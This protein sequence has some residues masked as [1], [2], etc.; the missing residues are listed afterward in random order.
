MRAVGEVKNY[1]GF[2]FCRLA[3]D[4]DFVRGVSLAARCHRSTIWLIVRPPA[5]SK[6]PGRRCRYMHHCNWKMLVENQTDTCHPMVAHESSA[7]TAVKLWEELDMP[8]GTPLPPAMEIIAPFTSPYEFFENMGIRTW[9]N[10]HGHTGV[11]HSIH[12]NYSAD[13]RVTWRGWLSPMARKRPRQ[14]WQRESAQ[15]R[16][17]PEHHDQGTDPAVAGFHSAGCRQNAWLKAISTAWLTVPR[18]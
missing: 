4:R 17:L 14:S 3:E 11:H 6:W 1:R 8:E 16:L 7:G 10:G 12:S 5:G 18:N 13:S 9:P 2:I 15:H